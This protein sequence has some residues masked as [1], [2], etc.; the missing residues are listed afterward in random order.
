[1]CNE[2]AIRDMVDNVAC[3]EDV[4]LQRTI[5]YEYQRLR[6]DDDILFHAIDAFGVVKLGDYQSNDWSQ[7]A[8]TLHPALGM[9]PSLR[10]PN[11]HLSRKRRQR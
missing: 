1:M 4:M 11:V 3:M 10:L 8:M 6:P 2:R 9:Q 7:L 5:P